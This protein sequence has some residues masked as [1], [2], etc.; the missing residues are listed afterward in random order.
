VCGCVWFLVV[1]FS[2]SLSLSLSLTLCVQDMRQR[3]LD[4]LLPLS[5]ANPAMTAPAN[6]A[7]SS[8]P[9]AND[10]TGGRGGGGGGGR[11]GQVLG[12]GGPRFIVAT[13]VRNCGGWI[14][15]AVESLRA[16]TYP[17]WIMVAFFFFFFLTYPRWIMAAFHS[18]KSV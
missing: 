4:T 12:D 15:Y 17:R 14:R 11:G 9:S 16:Q 13:P 2:L 7:H 5:R 10:E 18:E 6:P 3:V 8:R 1:C